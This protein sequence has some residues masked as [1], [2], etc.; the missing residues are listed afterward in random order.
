MTNTTV[1]LNPSVSREDV[2]LFTQLD[3][4]ACEAILSRNSVGR[5]AFSLHDRVS[6]VPI[7]YVYDGGWIYG[8]TAAAGK[9]GEILRNRRI[10][11]EVDEHSQLFEWRSVVARG[12]LYLIG[13]GSGAADRRLYAKAASLIRKLLPAALTEADPV[14]FRDQ[15][16]RIRAVEISGRA[17]VPTGGENQTLA[18]GWIVPEAGDP[19]ADGVLAGRIDSAL[20][21]LTLSPRSQ[22]RVDALDGVIALTGIAEDG[23]ERAAVETA[24][25]GVPGVRAVVQQLETVF[26]SRQQ[27]TPTEIAREA[28]RQLNESP[29]VTDSGIRIVEEHG[30]LRVEGYANSRKTRDDVVRR[31]RGVK[32]SRG[33]I[34]KLR[35][36]SPET[37][38][39]VGD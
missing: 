15:L 23:P 31:L 28:L 19:E 12:P 33:V 30:W 3:R 36:V 38:Q 37:T 20:A 21:N 18:S 10:A 26:P 6:I 4:K 29:R 8:R 27:P 5:I 1:V 17:S 11:F 35:I 34:D 32:G 2:P 14:P 24:V 7:H 16:F 9:L 25:L 22:I 39:V 13:L